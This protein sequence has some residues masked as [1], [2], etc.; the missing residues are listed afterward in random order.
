MIIKPLKLVSNEHSYGCNSVSNNN[1][2]NISRYVRNYITIAQVRVGL[3]NNSASALRIITNYARKRRLWIHLH[4]GQSEVSV[5]SNMT[6]T[7]YK[8]MF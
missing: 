4:G 1:H 7:M 8:V 2:F 5:E 3:H 6:L